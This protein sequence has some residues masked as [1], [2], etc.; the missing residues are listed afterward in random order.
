[1]LVW[2]VVLTT[3]LGVL[4]LRR[5]RHPANFP[6]SPP[7]FL[8]FGNLLESLKPLITGNNRKCVR[9]RRDRYGDIHGV[10]MPTGKYLIHLSTFE[11][12]KE[13]C[14]MPEFSG[15]AVLYTL[16]V[17]SYMKKMGIIFNDGGV[18]SEQRRFALHHLRNLGFGK[19][20]MEHGILSEFD[21][22]RQEMELKAGQ[23]VKVNTLF[24]VAVLNVLWRLV[25]SSRL[26]PAD[27]Q[28]LKY[29]NLVNDFFKHIV[30]P[31]LL[32]APWLRHVVPVRS[33]Y[34]ALVEQRDI[35]LAMFKRLVQE[36]RDTL[37]PNCPRDY[38]DHF[39]LEMQKED[40]AA[41]GFTDLGMAI[42][43]MDLFIGGMDTTSTSLSW[44][45]LYM[46]K[47][48]EVQRR[49]QAEIDTVL[50]GRHPTSQD[51][52]RMPYTDAT[53]MEVLRRSTTI[54][55][56][57][58]HAAS[59]GAV[60]FRGYVIPKDSIIMMHLED[61]H[62]DKAYWGDPET[63]RPERFISDNGTARR[64]ERL[65][66]FGIGKR[67]CLGESLARME[68]FLLFV[69]TLQRFSF[70]AVAGEPLSEDGLMGGLSVP[71][72]FHVTY[73]VRG[74]TESELVPIPRPT[75]SSG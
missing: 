44:A 17:R 46:V 32:M 50:S 67:A 25:A 58:P 73:Q 43:G 3:L 29:V 72:Q 54:P 59:D 52:L 68:L 37:D 18:W 14:K 5:P 22:M 69:C 31:I 6:P 24:N 34:A 35:F 10:V 13:A 21:F 61:V 62:M 74:K 55:R 57:V 26:N 11:D 8:I 23:P 38:I 47:H 7:T 20:S 64:D 63:F 71:E 2:L 39:L 36:H 45:L 15:R 56:G 27:P 48:P 1:M 33:G 51:R 40:A 41:R 53:L 42:S 70:T 60:N 28:S 4:W 30:S 75:A 16:L 9:E 66:P 12:I 65:I 19:S 49:V